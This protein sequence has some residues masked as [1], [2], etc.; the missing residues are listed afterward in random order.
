MPNRGRGRQQATSS[1][2]STSNNPLGD[3]LTEEEYQA[4]IR[5]EQELA[6]R[7]AQIEGCFHLNIPD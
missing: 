6:T 5:A 3:I 4:A 7:R 1:S 2:G